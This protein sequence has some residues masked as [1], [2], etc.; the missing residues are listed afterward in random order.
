MGT[1]IAGIRQMGDLHGSDRNKVLEMY[2]KISKAK[3]PLPPAIAFVFDREC[4]TQQ[5]KDDWESLPQIQVRVLPRRMFGNYLLDPDAVAAEKESGKGH[6]QRQPA[7]TTSFTPIDRDLIR[8][9]KL[10]CSVETSLTR[11]PLGRTYFALQS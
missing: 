7:T 11:P 10:D 5:Q 4:T 9:C 2:R 8:P 3:T 1:A 6:E